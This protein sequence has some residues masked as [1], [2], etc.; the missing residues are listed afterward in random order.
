[1]SKEVVI[2]RYR[3]LHARAVGAKAASSACIEIISLSASTATRVDCKGTRLF[4]FYLITFGCI[5]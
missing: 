5:M 4:L 3:R 1:M 2:E